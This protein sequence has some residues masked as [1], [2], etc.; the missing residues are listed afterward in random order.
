MSYVGSADDSFADPAL[1]VA[2]GLI[3]PSA[4]RAGSTT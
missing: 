1:E 3:L 2:V 4:D